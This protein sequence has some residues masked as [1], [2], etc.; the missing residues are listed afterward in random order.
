VT[1]IDTNIVDDQD[2]LEEHV[3]ERVQLQI[4]T[5]YGPN[6]MSDYTRLGLHDIVLTTYQT[7][8]AD[9]KVCEL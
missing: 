2:Q 3:D 1:N 5:Y 8:T 7:L 6:R 9:V 4:Y